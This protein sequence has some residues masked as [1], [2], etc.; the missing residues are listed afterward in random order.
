MTFPRIKV[1]ISETNNVDVAVTSVCISPNGEL[2]AAASLDGIV[3][4]WDVASGNLVERLIGHHGSVHSIVFIPNSCG[5]ITAS[6][7]TELKHWD[8]SSLGMSSEP[9]VP[10]Q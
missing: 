2:V 5:L 4:I 10:S 3:R 7:D 8:I 1:T 6:S 9:L